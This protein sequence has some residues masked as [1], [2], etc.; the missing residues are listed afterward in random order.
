MNPE[1][2]N[3]TA[4]NGNANQPGERPASLSLQQP[5]TPAPP[6][7]FIDKAWLKIRIAAMNLKKAGVVNSYKQ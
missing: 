3:Q 5:I 2:Q 4:P 1:N 6:N 7:P